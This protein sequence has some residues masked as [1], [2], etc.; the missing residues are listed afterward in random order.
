MSRSL[1]ATIW[2][3]LLAGLAHAASSPAC[4][5]LGQAAALLKGFPLQ[6]LPVYEEGQEA[7]VDKIAGV[8]WS[9]GAPLITLEAKAP[10]AS[11][12]LMRADLE[13]RLVY[14]LVRIE[15]E[16]DGTSCVSFEEGMPHAKVFQR[17]PHNRGKEIRL[18]PYF[19]SDSG[20]VR[21]NA[22]AGFIGEALAFECGIKVG[23]EGLQELL[24]NA[25]IEDAAQLIRADGSRAED[26]RFVKSGE[27]TWNG[28]L[29]LV[30]SGLPLPDPE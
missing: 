9:K 18:D 25:S 15:H 12:C 10:A 8:D 21:M 23:D 7:P 17:I 20:F 5:P 4:F 19:E 13:K 29:F 16:F 30:G 22:R 27:Y 2:V 11:L 26:E 24:P 28:V 14:R 1:T 6:G 3:L